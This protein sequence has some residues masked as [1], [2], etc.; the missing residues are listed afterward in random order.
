MAL[1]KILKATSEADPAGTPSELSARAFSGWLEEAGPTSRAP[2]YFADVAGN[3]DVFLNSNR[4]L[5]ELFDI[6]ENYIEVEDD[7]DDLPL[8]PPRTFINLPLAGQ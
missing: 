3:Y 6:L 4:D 2:G 1:G 5:W 8:T 7:E